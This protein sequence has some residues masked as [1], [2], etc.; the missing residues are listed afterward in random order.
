[1]A[2]PLVIRLLA[3]ALLFIFAAAERVSPVT[4]VV[5][6]LGDLKKEVESDGQAEA[7]AYAK[8]A[9]FCKDTTKAKSESVTKGQDTIES[10]SADITDNSAS[11]A[12]K[13][14]DVQKRKEA[15]KDMGNDL[16]ATVARCSTAQATYE[17]GAADMTKAIASLN[18][19]IAAMK[20]TKGKIGA[21]ALL[22]ADK[23]VQAALALAK[24][25]PELK[26]LGRKLDPNDPA[27]KYHS[28]AINDILAKLLTEFKSE[29]QDN[30][31]TWAITSAACKAEK[32]GL[33]QKM[34]T[35]KEAITSNQEKIG[36]LQKRIAK[37]R[38]DLVN[39]QDAMQEDEAYLKDLT[40]QCETKATDFDQ[41]ASMRN[42]ELQALTQALTILGSK[43]EAADKAVN[44]RA[45]VQKKALPTRK[46]A[47][48]K[49]VSLLQAA[50]VKAVTNF[51]AREDAS[52]SERVM[53]ERLVSFLRQE[54]TRIVSP[55]LSALAMRLTEDHFKEVKSMVQKLIERLLEEEAV[56]AS[57]KGF[58]DQEIAMAQND[59]D[60]AHQQVLSMSAELKVLEASK[61]ELEA[62]SKQLKKDIE[63]GSD[64]LKES[65]DLRQKEKD[66]NIE[67]L[68][69]AK[70][71]LSALN[72]A[73]LVLKS[74]YADASRGSALLQASPVD[75]DTSGPGYAGSY[76][77][78]QAGSKTIFALLETIAADFSMTIRKT[79]AAEDRAAADFVKLDRAAKETIASK[80][81]K[82]K[83]DE[84]DLRSTNTQIEKT[85][86]DLKT[87]SGLVDDA[88]KM[89]EGLRP[90]CLDA[91][92]MNFKERQ[93]K[94]NEEVAAL[95]KALEILTPQKK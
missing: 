18:K 66:D 2:P 49:K 84:Q 3:A 10:L 85:L 58:C 47:P 91:G 88:L 31:D 76:Q 51:L 5:K 43:V 57:K 83:L 52:S 72:E 60:H 28:K 26:L 95:R 65:L 33:T 67:T 21:A 62:E 7:A 73:I 20:A 93:T 17:A 82:I 13:E 4:K 24:P 48:A 23:D 59:R 81:T 32:D 27:Y 80:N 64:E 42:N 86:G 8:Y 29:Q 46:A 55:E 54:G 22:Q 75:A 94:R 87:S 35:N 92:G 11:Q 15:D 9:C 25:K 77:G 19:A 45:F 36:N 37:A 16:A 1:M 53:Q 89:I 44:D 14:T 90:T 50:P 38:G 34:K 40:L 70:E 56:E 12:A 69:T 6:L 41:R 79:E 74:F 68:K 61:E 78:N 30:A 63:T 71:G 39:A